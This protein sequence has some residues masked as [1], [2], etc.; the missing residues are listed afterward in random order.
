MKPFETLLFEVIAE[1][2]KNLSGFF[3][4]PGMPSITLNKLKS[5]QCSEK[6]GDLKKLNTLNHKW[7]TNVLVV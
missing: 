3:T 2:L 5:N 4:N 1:I 7:R 6:G